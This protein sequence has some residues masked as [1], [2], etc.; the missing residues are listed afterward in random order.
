MQKEAVVIQI[1]ALSWNI[2]EGPRKVTKI[3][4]ED[5]PFPGGYLKRAP[6]NYISKT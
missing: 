5:G 3:F 2:L 4:N 6:P 1:E